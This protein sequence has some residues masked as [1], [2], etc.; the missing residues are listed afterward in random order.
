MSGEN[1]AGSGVMSGASAAW[2]GVMSGKKAIR[3]LHNRS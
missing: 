2:S 1:T 3:S